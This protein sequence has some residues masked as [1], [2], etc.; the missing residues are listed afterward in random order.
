MYT[1]LTC[2]CFLYHDQRSAADMNAEDRLNS[3]ASCAIIYSMSHKIILFR[4]KLHDVMTKKKAFV[5]T[6]YARDFND[7]QKK[8]I[9]A[10]KRTV[11][12]TFFFFLVLG[13]RFYLFYWFHFLMINA[14]VSTPPPV[15]SRAITVR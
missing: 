10:H 14:T 2:S 11:A 1:L 9:I 5:P 8:K 12:A 7:M 3:N 6:F 13:S 4:R 15:L